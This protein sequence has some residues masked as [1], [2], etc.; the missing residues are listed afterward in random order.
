MAFSRHVSN[1][2]ADSEE[3]SP[4]ELVQTPEPNPQ[5]EG[6]ERSPPRSVLSHRFRASP[7]RAFE[8]TERERSS[9][10]VVVPPPARPWEY[11]PFQGDTTVDTV[12]EE[13]EGSDGVHRYKIE[14]EDG[15]QE[16]VSR[17]SASSFM[18]FAHS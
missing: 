9:V 4:V 6:A 14:Y 16:D 7:L 8:Q 1:S 18:P 12:L 10:A 13:I 11:Q 15:Q 3:S 5:E 2:E 17:I